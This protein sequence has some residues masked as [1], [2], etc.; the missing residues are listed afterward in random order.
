MPDSTIAF[1]SDSWNIKACLVREVLYFGG[2]I[3]DPNATLKAD[4]KLEQSAQ[5]WEG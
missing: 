4:L 1:I 3:D 2:N 5:E